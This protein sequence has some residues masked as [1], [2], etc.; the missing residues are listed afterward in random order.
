MKI[1]L[2]WLRDYVDVTLPVAQLA[3][4]LSLAGLEVAGIQVIGL[5]I[6]EGVRVKTEEAG[7]VWE[8]DKV[9]VAQIVDVAK[10]PDADRLKLVTVDYGQQP[11]VIVT[12]ASNVAVGDKGQKVILALTGATLIDGHAEGRVL[13]QLKPTKIRGVPSDAMVCSAK[14]LG[15]ADEHEG[16]IILED[17]APIGMPL[18]D[19]M[20]DVVFE[21]DVLPNMARCLAMIGVAR[22][23]A[24][25]TGQTLKLPPHTLHAIGEPVAGQVNVVI[26]DATLCARYAAA[27]LA[28]IRLG[29]SPGWMQRRLQLVG[30]RPIN[31][32]VDVTNYVMLEWGQPLHAFDYD[33][34]TQRSGGKPP[35]IT[36]RT[37]R[38]GETLVTL[39]GMKR[40][41]T[42][43]HLL[44][45]DAMGPIA[46]A[47]VM[48]GAETEV[49]AATKNVLLESANFNFISIR[50]TARHFDLLS[51]ASHRFS[52]G[53][54]PEMVRP[55]AE[56][57]LELLR[58]C[59]GATVSKG[60]AEQY[61]APVKVSPITLQ[62]AE[63]K[64]VLGFDFPQADAIRI[65]NALE[66]D[67]REA[68][69]VLNVTPPA[70]RMDLQH[71]PAD[72]IEEL[73]R[74]YG[75]DRMP[76]TL[77]R[78]R[79]PEPH[80]ER[81]LEVEEKTR[82]LLVQTGLQE[83]ITYSLTAPE[84]ERPIVGA[85]KDYVR[86][87]NPIS[88][89]RVV[90]RRSVLAS[91]LEVAARN[92]RHVE[93]VRFFEIGRAYIPRPDR[94]LPDEPGRLAMVMVG[95][96]HEEWWT[97]SAA[98]EPVDFFDL[99]GIVA[100]LLA[101]LH[102]GEVTYF[103]SKEAWLHPGKS[104]E[105][106][107][108]QTSL[109]HFGQ[110]HPGLNEHFQ[111]G[112]REVFVGEFDLHAILAAVPGRFTVRPLSEFPPVRQ[113][114]AIVVDETL[115][116]A[117]V[118]DEIRAG[119]TDMLVNVRLFDVY[120]GPNIPTGKKSLA[121]ALTYQANDRTLTDKEVAR[122][123]GKI[124]TRLEKVLKAQLRS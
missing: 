74:I 37:A 50:R 71:G 46:L 19:F 18:A 35:T 82:D 73:A 123:H 30:M 42:A 103:S 86:L 106:M 122:V 7:P 87:A 94:S 78:D 105:V 81:S 85:D 24:A 62:L 11:K 48:G 121:Y 91:I 17:A 114:V 5:P 25:L 13:K 84:R 54:H 63:V 67:V 60:F 70:H 29:P 115:P 83:V 51:E 109:G 15:L 39:D 120:R 41:L 14:E 12:G 101:R 61:P 77:L 52:R 45:A 59:A 1:P 43:D 72:L 100:A 96:R 33:K 20:G 97:G 64:R 110:L 32:V 47:G 118:E 6:P 36:V 40:E 4:R 31:N 56:R 3:E 90:M 79:L 66:F 124:V 26:A 107:A 53:V 49:S 88:S 8:R 16:I 34:L 117:K 27:L 21:I 119:G 23:V 65:L 58:G 76:A 75:Y 99:K 44:I 10:H 95:P 55:A 93:S 38:P 28:G 22:E 9:V 2:N 57:A 116:A 102:V 112:R 89:E 113:D 98:S 111:L 68:P 104:A 92:L 108:A 80:D 69:G